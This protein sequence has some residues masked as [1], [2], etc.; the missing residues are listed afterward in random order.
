MSKRQKW[1]PVRDNDHI[2]EREDNWT[3]SVDPD[4]TGWETNDGEEGNG[5]PFEVADWICSVLNSTR[6]DCG[7]MLDKWG[8]WKKLVGK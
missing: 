4:H 3:I 1:Y 7:Y 2:K 5:L 8:Y 6:G